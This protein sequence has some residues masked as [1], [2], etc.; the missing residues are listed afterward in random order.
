MKN[1]E[2]TKKRKAKRKLSTGLYKLAFFYAVLLLIIG[3]TLGVVYDSFISKGMEDE[4]NKIIELSTTSEILYASGEE[5]C[6]IFP[7]TMKEIEEQTWKLG[8]M[9]DELESKNRIGEDLKLK[10]FDLQVRDFF[11]VKKA[12]KECRINPLI[13]MYFYTNNLVECEECY[14]QGFEL[15]IARNSLLEKVPIKIYAF[16]G[17]TSHSVVNYFKEKY[18]ISSYPSLVFIYLEDGEERWLKEEGL[19][20]SNQILEKALTFQNASS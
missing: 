10:Y 8:V 17:K 19:I 9:I 14:E 15:A 11:L 18:N 12:S 7:R 16:E 13:I 1:E 6:T 3:F 2:K 5:F 4:I 20:N